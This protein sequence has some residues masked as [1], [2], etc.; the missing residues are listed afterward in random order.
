MTF[1]FLAIIF[2]GW[3]SLMAI[4]VI[5]RLSLRNTRVE[6]DLLANLAMGQTP[7]NGR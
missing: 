4:G 3:I 1:A 5:Y 2:L 7:N 6:K